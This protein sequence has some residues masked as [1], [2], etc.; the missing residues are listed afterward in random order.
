[1][2]F[3]WSFVSSLKR[4]INES[5]KEEY[6]FTLKGVDLSKTYKV[7]LDNLGYSFEKT[8]ADLYMNG[9]TVKVPASMSSELVLYEAL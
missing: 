4:N 8:G 3:R 6:H 5:K 9:L 2:D 1:M 7:T